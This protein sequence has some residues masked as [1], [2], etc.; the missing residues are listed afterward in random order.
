[1]ATGLFFSCASSRGLFQGRETGSVISLATS[2]PLPLNCSVPPAP[3][4]DIKSSPV[5]YK[6]QAT[7]GCATGISGICEI[8]GSFCGPLRCLEINYGWFTDGQSSAP[9]MNKITSL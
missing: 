3:L 4:Q 6:L 1:M 5:N 2:S 7:T 8:A 9:A